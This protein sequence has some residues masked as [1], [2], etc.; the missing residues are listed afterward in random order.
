MS[1]SDR[2]VS[3]SARGLRNIGFR[4]EMNDFEF[5]AGDRRHP[6]PCFAALSRAGDPRLEKDSA[7]KDRLQKHSRSPKRRR[8]RILR[9][10]RSARRTQM[11]SQFFFSLNQLRSSRRIKAGILGLSCTSFRVAFDGKSTFLSDEFRFLSAKASSRTPPANSAM[12]EVS[13]DS[14]HADKAEKKWLIG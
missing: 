7:T 3:L 10:L 12:P 4:D 13:A 9:D 11:N 6:R 5:I 8:R 14:F 1:E 2:L